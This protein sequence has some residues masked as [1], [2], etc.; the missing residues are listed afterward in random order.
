MVIMSKK[1]MTLPLTA[2]KAVK[3]VAIAL[4]CAKYVINLLLKQV[5]IGLAQF[6]HRYC[7]FSIY[8]NFSGIL[9]QFGSLILFYEQKE[10]RF[11]T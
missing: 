2:I 7:S 9:R 6:W 11:R 5:E 8:L 4:N 1:T 10:K 3:I